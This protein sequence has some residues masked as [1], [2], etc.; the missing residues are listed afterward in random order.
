MGVTLGEPC[1]RPPD[2]VQFL[3]PSRSYLLTLAN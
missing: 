2:L 3:K 1:E